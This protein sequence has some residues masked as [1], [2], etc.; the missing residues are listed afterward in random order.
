MT[1]TLSSELE[2]S[3]RLVQPLLATLK[4]LRAALPA[5]TAASPDALRVALSNAQLVASIFY[6]LNSPGLTDAFEETL[7]DWMAEFYALL[8][9]DAPSVAERDPD[10]ESVVDALKA[11]VRGWGG[12]SPVVDVGGLA[13]CRVSGQ[14]PC[15]C[16]A[17]QAG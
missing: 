16:G 2:Y 6:S 8:T 9:L 10:R 7:Q 11:T 13:G 1:D 14:G 4:K 17:G 3:Q 5:A 12:G 15:V